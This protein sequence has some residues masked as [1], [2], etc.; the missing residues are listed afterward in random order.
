[1]NDPGMALKIA[2]DFL[3]TP[4]NNYANIDMFVGGMSSDISE[5]LNHLLGHNSVPQISYASTS[6][7]MSDKTEFPTFFRTVPSDGKLVEGVVGFVEKMEWEIMS[8][9]AIESEFGQSVSGLLYKLL[10]NNGVEV[11]NNL[12]YTSLNIRDQLQ[13]I[14]SSESRVI[15]LHCSTADAQLVF[16][17]AYRMG[18]VEEGWT[19]IGSEWA[20]D[21]LLDEFVEHEDVAPWPT[22]KVRKEELVEEM[23]GIVAIRTSNSHNN[24]AVTQQIDNYLLGTDSL[25]G[26]RFVTAQV[27]PSSVTNLPIGRYCT[28]FDT[29]HHVSDYAYF[30][31]DAVILAAT[32]LDR[33]L[34]DKN[35]VM[36]FTASLEEMR[37]LEGTEGI[38]GGATGTSENPI[39][40]DSKGDRIMP[41]DVVNLWAKDWS[42]LVT[43]PNGQ[44]VTVGIFEQK[45]GTWELVLEGDDNMDKAIKWPGGS[46]EI[47]SDRAEEHV[48]LAALYLFFFLSFIILSICVGNFLHA[49]EFYVLPESGATVLF[50]LLLG[51]VLTIYSD[52]LQYES[53]LLEMTEFD[54]EI[55]SLFLLPVIIFAAGF[56]L[57]KSDFLNN[58]GPICLT[59]LLGTAISTTFVGLGV[60]Y[61]GDAGWF[62]FGSLGGAESMAFGALISAVDPVAILAVFGALG[63]E[64]DLNMRVF[65]ESVI[66]DGVSIVLF[67]VMEKFITEEV[68]THEVLMGGV[69]FIRILFGSIGIGILAALFL[70]FV[71]K[72][73]RLHSHV[74]EA[75]M[76]LLGSY[77]AYAGA[78]AVHCSGIIASL[79]C[80]IAMNHWT[81][82]NFTYDGEMLSRRTVKMFSLLADTVIFFQVGQNIVVNVVDP[83]WNFIGI[84]L[85]LCLVGRALNIIPLLSLYNCCA[86]EGRQVPFKHMLV[87]VHAGLRGAIAFA[88]ALKFPSQ[89][90]HVVINTCLWVI[91]F[92]IFVLG[93]T[94]V[95]WL[96]MMGVEMGV[97]SNDVSGVK[98][99]KH[100]EGFNNACHKFDRT[101]LLPC[102]TWRFDSDGKD[103]YHHLCVIISMI[104]TPGLTE[105]Y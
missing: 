70:A 43:E 101:C 96:E 104:G 56:N 45:A 68:T 44:W 14:R 78:E 85:L 91:L 93:G 25:T 88:L 18:M 58:L 46:T 31:Y 94:C 83:D 95:A 76:V 77:A 89:H 20:Q 8:I 74:L 71:M 4:W 24:V 39:R 7:T 26:N 90:I 3:N 36:N 48:S 23:P 49:H 34:S 57:R 64:T 52:W 92:T 75:G 81:Y 27:P 63:V 60:Y 6:D 30:A 28:G 47:P 65:G 100:S 40:L 15:F 1:M 38:M 59:A 98:K 21:S 42:D 55:F 84:T 66:N 19:W 51:G 61:A 33:S 69:L 10:S 62:N 29:M 32:A 72:Y 11:A 97:K 86:K 102:V 41:Y 80:G 53:E 35:S 9:L 99:S 13:S 5:A 2:D 103:T 105:I 50:G 82:H 17:W 22:P 67:K 87:M 54:T 79:F 37:G 73:A 12:L 16:E